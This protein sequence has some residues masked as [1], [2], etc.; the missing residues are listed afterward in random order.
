MY[1]I[2]C[3]YPA[4]Q[5]EVNSDGIGAP[6][7]FV[8]FQG[9]HLRCYAKTLGTLCDTPEGLEGK[10]GGINY[11]L[12][13]LY[14]IINTQ[15][16]MMGGVKLLC[17]TGGDPLWRKKEPMIE[18]FLWLSKKGFTMSIETS[19][20]LSIEPYRYIPN[21]HFVLDYKLKMLAFPMQ[22]NQAGASGAL[23]Q[24][25][26]VNGGGNSTIVYFGSEDC[27]I[28]E[29]RI[30]GAGGKVYQS[31]Q[32]LGEYGFMVLALDTE[33]NMIGVHSMK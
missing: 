33:G 32:S 21:V 6:V 28:E 5:G 16:I 13:D 19:G 24:M 7:I 31:K 11:S 2:N 20:T 27:A 26:G 15:S 10:S 30:E 14:T 22:E 9:C 8:R 4:F 29:A 25:E 18:L 17:I 12:N 23:I 1:Y 3:V